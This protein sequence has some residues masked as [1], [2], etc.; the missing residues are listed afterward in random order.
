MV[1]PPSR[2]PSLSGMAW[3]LL[4]AV[5]LFSFL[6]PPVAQAQ[7]SVI[8]RETNQ[9]A[10]AE[11]EAGIGLR[12]GSVIVAPIPFS[13]PMVG[14][15]LALG[16]G[17]LFQ[18]DSASKPSVLGL[19][20]LRSDNGSQAYGASV[21]LAFDANRWLLS[22]LVAQADLNY[23]LITLLGTTPI[24]Q[25]GLLARL[26]LSYGVTS[27][28]SF[29]VLLRYLDTSISLQSASSGG[30]AARY[31]PDVKIGIFSYGFIS[32]LDTRD[33]T[34]YPTSGQRIQVTA[35]NAVILNGP[36]GDYS[37]AFMTYDIYQKMGPSSVVAL[38]AALCGASSNA[39]FYDQCSIG[40]TDSFRGFNA[41]QF[42]DSRSASLQAEFRQRVT[43]RLGLVMFAGAGAVGS[44]FDDLSSRGA[45]GG[46]GIRYRVS[47]KFPV[48]FAI[49]G[50]YNDDDEALL[51][52]SVGQRF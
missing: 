12:K 40:G 14:S 11:N 41:T 2:M 7:N 31:L 49:D 1:A 22:A 29:G 26:S 9:I 37:K 45:A 47:K 16:A 25:Q 51:Y 19:G 34:L 32:E 10:A 3:C 50:S 36:G 43:P 17:Y 33:D 38:R 21:T 30:L 18:T 48:D 4:I 44:H 46:L 15:G 8:E 52:I 39:P 24:N 23:D 35:Q 28:L 5:L 13:N 6:C 20:A 42:L 27:D